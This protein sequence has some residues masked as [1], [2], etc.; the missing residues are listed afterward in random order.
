[1]REWLTKLLHGKC[2]QGAIDL[3]NKMR[4]QQQSEIDSLQDTIAALQRENMALHK[5][6]LFTQVSLNSKDI[7]DDRIS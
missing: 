5:E 4:R 6:I 7:Q 2:I 1:M 3:H